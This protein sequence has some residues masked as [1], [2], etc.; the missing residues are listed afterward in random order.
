MLKLLTNLECY[1]PQY[2]GKKD[3]LISCDKIIKICMTG[4][5]SQNNIISNIIPCDG[6]LAFPGLIDQHVHII[7]GGGE[8]GPISR[9][10]EIEFEDIIMA[11]VTS[12]VGVLG[13]DSFTRSLGNLLAKARGLEVQGLTTFIYR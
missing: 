12:L 7:G 6:L 1:C 8:E 2:V 9:I 11:G 3:I 4:E 5:L 10:K 13:V